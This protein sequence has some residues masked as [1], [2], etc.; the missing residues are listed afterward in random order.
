M[1]APSLVDYFIAN[2]N[3]DDINYAHYDVAALDKNGLNA[4]MFAFKFNKM[5]NLNYHQ[6]NYLLNHSDLSVVDEN[7]Q[8]ALMH[9][10]SFGSSTNYDL[11]KEQTNF[12]IYN[13]NLLNCDRHGRNALMFGLKNNASSALFLDSKQMNYLLR[14]SNLKQKT[15]LNLNCLYYAIMNDEE[16]LTLS[17]NQWHYLIDLSENNINALMSAIAVDNALDNKY[18]KKII[19]KHK[20]KKNKDVLLQVLNYCIVSTDFDFSIFWNNFEDKKYLLKMLVEHNKNDKYK[21]LIEKKE[22]SVF[23]ER[24]IIKKSLLGFNSDKANI[25]KI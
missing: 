13:S 4:L 11:T 10:F 5:L 7:K 14:H 23:V 15:Y 6:W 2:G 8:D 25:I 24:K 12:L 20:L 21:L 1:K 17:K 9:A 16:C 18:I 3:S 19:K 22:V